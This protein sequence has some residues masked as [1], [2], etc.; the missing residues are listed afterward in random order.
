MR[1]SAL[2][3][4]NLCRHQKSRWVRCRVVD[5]LIRLS[6]IGHSRP[7]VSVPCCLTSMTRS[8]R[9]CSRAVRGHNSTN[10]WRTGAA[11]G[12]TKCLCGQ[13]LSRALQARGSRLARVS[14]PD[15]SGEPSWSVTCE[16]WK[17]CKLVELI[18]KRQGGQSL[19][20]TSVAILNIDTDVTDGLK[21]RLCKAGQQSQIPLV[22]VCDDG[23]VTVRDELV[24]KCLCLEV[25]HELL[26]VEQAL[27]RMTQR[28]G[29]NRP[30][31][32][33]SIAIASGHDVRKA[34]NTAQLL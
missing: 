28:N 21:W 32:C 31:A 2:S 29:L 9:T 15:I 7:R 26:N 4:S 34:I 19:R 11:P 5:T 14:S 8:Q 22:F 10:G 17:K 18:L 27:R 24:Q 30:E 1:R 12:A 23:V 20:Q 25:R 3:Q 13:F 33:L 16:K 6:R